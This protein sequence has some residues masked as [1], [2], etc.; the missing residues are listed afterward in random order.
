MEDGIPRKF[1][2]VNALGDAIDF[3]KSNRGIKT[4]KDILKVVEILMSRN[5]GWVCSA[6]PPTQIHTNHCRCQEGKQRLH[7]LRIC[8]SARTSSSPCCFSTS[9]QV[10]RRLPAAYC[11]NGPIHKREKVR[12]EPVQNKRAL[13]IRLTDIRATASGSAAPVHSTRASP[14][15]EQ[16]RGFP[17]SNLWYL[18]KVPL[19]INLWK[20]FPPTWT[21]FIN[22]RKFQF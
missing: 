21:P 11:R 13:Q 2:L 10:G 17:L 15:R 4:C 16:Q 7:A 18:I 5:C 14:L 9:R 20:F 8:P 12:P 3:R 22:F 1:C 6:L 19:L